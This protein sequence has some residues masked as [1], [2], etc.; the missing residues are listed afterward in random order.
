AK[1]LDA[2]KTYIDFAL[3]TQAQNLGAGV[4]AYQEL[5]NPKAKSDKRIIKLSRVKLVDYDFVKAA[6]RKEALTARFDLEV[7]NRSTARG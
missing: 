1:N 3:S 6:A 2:A 4:A 7:V 5:T